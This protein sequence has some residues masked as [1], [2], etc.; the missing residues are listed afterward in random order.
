[1]DWKNLQESL[2]WFQQEGLPKLQETP[3]FRTIFFG[4]DRDQGRAAAVTF[5]ESEA[6]RVGSEATEE[7]LRTAAVKLAK[8]GRGRVVDSY[9][10]PVAVAGKGKPAQARLSRWSGLNGSQLD[11]ALDL[12]VRERLPLLKESPGFSGCFVGL[13]TGRGRVFGVFLWDSPES[14]QQSADWEHETSEGLKSETGPSRRVLFETYEVALVPELTGVER[15]L[16]P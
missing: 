6:A 13:N 9:E 15:A 4:V 8:I 11:Q 16:S 14:L 1:M 5:W 12:F 10:V 2:G 7:E 3:G